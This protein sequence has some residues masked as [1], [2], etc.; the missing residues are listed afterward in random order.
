MK[1]NVMK[2]M[3]VMDLAK[4]NCQTMIN[5]KATTK[6]ANVTAK[7][8]TSKTLNRGKKII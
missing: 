1:A 2:T 5:T 4:L 8:L 6:T 7:A 3:N